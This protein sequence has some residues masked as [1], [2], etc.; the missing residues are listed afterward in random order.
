M[1]SNLQEYTFTV[2]PIN[3]VPIKR[4]KQYRMTERLNEYPDQAHFLSIEKLIIND[5][6]TPESDS[7]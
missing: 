6:C 2:V 7:K 4:R 5:K 1:K 3:E